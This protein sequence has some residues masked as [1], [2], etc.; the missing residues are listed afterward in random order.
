MSLGR[1]FWRLLVRCG[2]AKIILPWLTPKKPP[3]NM[4]IDGD[5]A[6]VTIV[7]L[8]RSYRI[9]MRLRI[10]EVWE[11]TGVQYPPNVVPD[12]ALIDHPEW[13][14]WQSDGLA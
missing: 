3:D 10:G 8:G 7:Y 1:W 9:P 2:V 14:F 12:Q 5:I 4:E 11:M 13:K 6:W